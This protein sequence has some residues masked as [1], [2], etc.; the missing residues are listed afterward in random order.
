MMY[1]SGDVDGLPCGTSKVSKRKGPPD[2]GGLHSR[3]TPYC[4]Q[5]A[6][7]CRGVH[8]IWRTRQKYIVPT[9]QIMTH[10]NAHDWLFVLFS[11]V[12]ATL[13]RFS[14]QGV[15]HVSR[16]LLPLAPSSALDKVG[17]IS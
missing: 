11:R 7:H 13:A 1:G 14:V 15:R 3:D 17:K 10:H 9:L 16:L 4:H 5:Y 6:D 8:T 12:C 2:S